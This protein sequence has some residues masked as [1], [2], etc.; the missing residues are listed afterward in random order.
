MRGF[1]PGKRRRIG[2]LRA[3]HTDIRAVILADQRCD[4]N[5]KHIVGPVD[6]A[7]VQLTGPARSV[8]LSV[9]RRQ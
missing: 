2:P 9:F 3:L 1:R 5:F 4:G 8:K 6:V 7:G